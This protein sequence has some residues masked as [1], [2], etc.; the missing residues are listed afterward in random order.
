MVQDVSRS[1]DVLGI[2]CEVLALTGQQSPF[3]YKTYHLTSSRTVLCAII[4][5]HLHGQFCFW[6][7]EKKLTLD[8]CFLFC[9]RYG[10]YKVSCQSRKF[11]FN[12]FSIIHLNGHN[13]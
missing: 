6:V 11:E 9:K 1:Q 10:L 12:V 13:V 3:N 5:I 7:F 2:R 4:A 8:N